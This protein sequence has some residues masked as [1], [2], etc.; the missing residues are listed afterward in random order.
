MHIDQDPVS[1]SRNVPVEV[2]IVGDARQVLDQLLPLLEAPQIGGWLEQLEDGTRQL[3]VGTSREA[4]GE[5][6]RVR[7]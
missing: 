2:P 6:M 7:R 1:I 5:F 4:E 3:L